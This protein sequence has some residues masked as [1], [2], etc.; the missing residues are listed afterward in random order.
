MR[1]RVAAAIFAVATGLC[2]SAVQAQQNWN[3]QAMVAS[4]A[5]AASSLVVN[6]GAGVAGPASLFAFT[7]I[8]ST[9][10]QAWAEVINATTAPADGALTAGT[11]SGD[12]ELCRE[13]PTGTAAVPS[14]YTYGAAGEPPVWFS[15]GITIVVS[16]TACATKTAATTQWIDAKAK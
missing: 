7:V 4:Q 9:G 5:G 1:N 8:N 6:N 14:S 13:L 11:A 3:A 2:A 10:A 15:V 12:I 16:S